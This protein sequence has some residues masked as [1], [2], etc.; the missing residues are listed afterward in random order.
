M[1]TKILSSLQTRMSFSSE[2]KLPVNLKEYQEIRPYFGTMVEIRLY[3]DPAID[4]S[5]VTQSCW[6][7][8]EQWHQHMNVFSSSGDLAKLNQD[9]FHGVKV[10]SDVYRVVKN[11]LRLAKMTRGTFD[12]TCLPLIKLW[13]NASQQGC[14]PDSNAVKGAQAMVGYQNIRLEGPDRVFF[15]KQ[16]MGIDLGGIV[17]GFACDELAKMLDANEIKHFLLDMG[18]ELFCRGLDHGQKPWM[19]GIQDP[20]DKTKVLAAAL[21]KDQGI[22]TSGSYEK[23][24]MI[25]GVKY[26]HI[27]DPMTGYPET[28]A[29]S[30][31][32]IARTAEE[33]DVLSTVMC[34]LGGRQ[35]L[36]AARLL[37]NV[38]VF[39]VEQKKDALVVYKSASLKRP[40]FAAAFNAQRFQQFFPVES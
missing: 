20:L 15:K 32:V 11:A 13:K 37:K 9:G 8:I 39:I 4:I 1:I 17:S 30:A 5:A 21:I 40:D 16:G 28:G 38:E 27:I 2:K 26:S 29:I 23:F 7:K 33:A 6:A 3:H 24:S 22:S 10:S 31:T 25:N 34:I 18:G 12:I 36:H 35:G 14:I 19:I